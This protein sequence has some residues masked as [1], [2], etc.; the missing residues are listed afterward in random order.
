MPY[1]YTVCCA[2]CV[3]QIWG[4]LQI[5]TQRNNADGLVVLCN[6]WG[7]GRDRSLGDREKRLG[8]R[9]GGWGQGGNDGELG[10]REGGLVCRRDVWGAWER[11]GRQERIVGTQGNGRKAG[12]QG[13]RV[14]RK[15]GLGG[16]GRSSG[17]RE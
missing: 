5:H 15:G 10:S 13:Q 8:N 1:T 2:Q 4:H 14:V 7:G 16:R 12:K 3:V 9:E 11:V 17:S 6:R